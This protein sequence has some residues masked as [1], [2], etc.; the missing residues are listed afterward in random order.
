MNILPFALPRN[1]SIEM[2]STTISTNLNCNL[3]CQHCYIQPELLRRKEYIDEPTFRR[4][5]E[6][7]IEA[8]HLDQSVTYLHLDVLGGEATLMPF[9][10]WQRNLP[11]VLSQI[12][13]LNRIG[14][15]TEFTFCSNLM[16]KDDRYL[17]L[18]REFKGHPAM[19]IAIPF[20]GP[21]SGRFGRGMA[22]LPK[23]LK[24]IEA[25]G[26]CNMLNLVLVM[27]QGL[28]DLGAEYIIE[29]FVKRGVT[30]ATCDMIFPWGSGK[31]YF[32][33]AQPQYHDV[34]E[35]I[36]T[37]ARLGKPYGLTVD[38]LDDM[39]KSLRTL[40]RSQNTLNDAYEFHWDQRGELSLNPNQTGTEALKPYINLNAHDANAALKVVWGNNSEL[41]NKL[42]Y[43]H[44]FC[45]DCQFL[46]ACN[47][48]WYPHK[49]LPP[50]TVRSYMQTSDDSF[51]CPGF[52]QLWDSQA[53]ENF[54]ELGV[55][56]YANIRRIKRAQLRKH[57][58][59]D[60]SA[61]LR[62]SDYSSD[63]EGYFE[64]VKGVSR[65]L[66][67]PI[68]LFGCTPRQRLWFYDRLQKQILLP[69]GSLDGF[70]ER[71][72]ILAHSLAG[73]YHSIAFSD[74]LVWAA[75]RAGPA[76]PLSRYVIDALSLASWAELPID[77][78]AGHTRQGS[79]LEV[80]HKFEDLL[81]W[82]L[83]R[84]PPSDILALVSAQ[85]PAVIT[86]ESAG[87]LRRISP[88]AKA[89]GSRELSIDH[90]ELSLD[91]VS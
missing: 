22:I 29:T 89:I 79:G 21:E 12:D 60:S 31:A 65:V 71:Y 23:Y 43:E 64:A 66:L 24:R 46:Q 51:S 84:R 68:E 86:D 75:L 15:Q 90:S 58:V 69:G 18:L 39:K 1:R 19:D 80:S 72:S 53:S 34:A 35:Y 61:P 41:D 48:G 32:D 82:S 30:D 5:V 74:D 70:D 63:Y 54:D 13:E 36:S 57:V 62:E 28:I 47:S 26:D 8:F 67:E 20:E 77:V 3:A 50:E 40:S 85:R 4:A 6:V 10:F 45:R 49:D 55:S 14:I 27:G 83:Y 52:F 76:T 44:D 73:N 56:K 78:K 11:W 33:R 7:I 38:H 91:G 81:I 87:F 9:E 2:M 25:L 16:W 37:L 42:S 17:G 88:I 59:A